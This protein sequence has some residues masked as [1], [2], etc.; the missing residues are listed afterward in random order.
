[1]GYTH[2]F[3]AKK[4]PTVKDWVN[5]LEAVDAILK[6]TDIPIVNESSDMAI[7]I[8]GVDPD[9]FETFYI[10]PLSNMFIGFN[11]CK[12][13]RRPYDT[14]VVA[15]LCAINAICSEDFDIGSDGITSDWMEGLAL[16]QKV[17]EKFG[18]PNT[19]GER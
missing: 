3:K 11:F 18:I 16:A 4:I 12:T 15:I 17:S 8:N 19:I 7:N 5:V 14:V 9:D 10:N 13:G 1:M 2:Y 6:E